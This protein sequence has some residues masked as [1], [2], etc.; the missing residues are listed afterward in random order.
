ML[1]VCSELGSELQERTATNNFVRGSKIQIEISELFDDIGSAA[2]E[3]GDDDAAPAAS[4][5][6]KED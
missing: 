6:A 3:F 5:E 2:D 4:E 1:T